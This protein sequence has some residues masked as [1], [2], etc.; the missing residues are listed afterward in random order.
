MSGMFIQGLTDP[1]AHHMN[2]RAMQADAMGQKVTQ[3]VNNT[4][5]LHTA[6]FRGEAANVNDAG[7]ENWRQAAHLKGQVQAQMQSDGVGQ[8]TNHY[9]QLSANNVSALGSVNMPTA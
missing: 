4:T 9:S 6:S 3:S 8:I 7:H 1:M 5:D 2:Q